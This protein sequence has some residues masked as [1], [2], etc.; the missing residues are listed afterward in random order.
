MS[1]RRFLSL[2]IAPLCAIAA[3]ALIILLSGS[4]YEFMIGEVQDGGKV[5]I[6]DLP[7]SMDD[8]TDVYAPATGALVVVFF[9]TGAVRSIRTRR[10]MPSLVLGCAI[11]LLWFYRFVWRTHG[12]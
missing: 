8:A 7:A 9:A 4:P 5:N 3:A 1:I 10:V 6:C 12:C 11:A 2:A